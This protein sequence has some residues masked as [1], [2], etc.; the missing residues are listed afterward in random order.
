V[1]DS[2]FLRREWRSAGL[3][4]AQRSIPGIFF[5]TDYGYVLC[6]IRLGPRGTIRPKSLTEPPSFDAVLAQ[7]AQ[8]ERALNAA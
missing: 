2:A 4:K 5:D 1:S 6:Q 8:A 7:L 3:C